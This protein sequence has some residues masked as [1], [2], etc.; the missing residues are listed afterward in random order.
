MARQLANGN[1]TSKIGGEEDITH[2]TLDALESHGVPHGE[3]GDPVL[4]MRRFIPVSWIVRTVQYSHW[5]FEILKEAYR[6]RKKKGKK[7]I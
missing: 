6:G 2:Y 5:K 4:Y 1:W 3:Y 7:V